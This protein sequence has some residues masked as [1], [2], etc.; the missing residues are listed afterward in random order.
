MQELSQRGGF[1][2]L[3][4]TP[5]YTPAKNGPH[6]D[7]CLSLGGAEAENVDRF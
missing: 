4:P 5:S 7:Y 1:G 6:D 3:H 2:C